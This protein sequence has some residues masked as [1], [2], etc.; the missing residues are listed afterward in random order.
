[1]FADVHE[2][3][4]ESASLNSLAFHG[5]RGMNSALQFVEGG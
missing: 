4:M 5:P 3:A 2:V 1:M